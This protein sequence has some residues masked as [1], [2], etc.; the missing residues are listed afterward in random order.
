M[1][2]L[3]DATGSRPNKQDDKEELEGWQFR[4]NIQ[5]GDFWNTDSGL[6]MHPDADNSK[7]RFDRIRVPRF[8]KFVD[9]TFRHPEYFSPNFAMDVVPEK[10]N[11]TWEFT[12][13]SNVETD[14]VNLSWKEVSNPRAEI[15]VLYDPDNE[16]IID[17]TSQNRYSYRSTPSKSLKVIYGSSDYLTEQLEGGLVFLGNNYPNPFNNKTII[18]FSLFGADRQ[19]DVELYVY[20]IRGNLVDIILDKSLTSGIYQ[21]EWEAV[22]NGLPLAGGLYIYI[23]RASSGNIHKVVQKKMIIK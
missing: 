16:V 8:V 5:A 19:Y 4:I 15:F 3:I 9:I 13:E 22:S 18:P 11:H 14:F 1:F 21:V 17:L 23:L 2:P 7:D 12:V 10:E 20:D 6:G